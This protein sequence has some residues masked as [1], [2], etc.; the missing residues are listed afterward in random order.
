[1]TDISRVLVIGAG[2]MGS[3][4]GL[5]A[6][7]VGLE[8]RIKDVDHAS[9]VVAGD[10]TGLELVDDSFVPDLV[11]IATPPVHIPAE[12]SGAL[13]MFPQCTVIDIASIKSQVINEVETKDSDE[14]RFIATH[15]MA[16][17]ESAGA[18][19]ASFD[20]FKD[21]IWVMCPSS[22]TES[23]RAIA[24]ED[25]ISKLGAVP[26]TMTASEHDRTVAITSHAAQ[27]VSSVLAAQLLEISQTQVQVSGQGLRDMTRIAASNPHLWSEILLA[28]ASF[29]EPVLNKMAAELMNIASHLAGGDKESIEASLTAGNQGRALVPGKHGEQPTL[30]DTVAI[31]IEDTPGQ[32]AAIF[33]VAGAV[34]V[35][36]EDVRI[37]HALG[38]AV[39]VI[40][41]DVDPASAPK[42]RSALTSEGWTLRNSPLS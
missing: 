30:Y 2:L 6:R 9:S 32:L 26:V 10:I 34:Q 5:A 23:D 36:I 18:A 1:V 15:P 11:V 31:L 7:E 28:N 16:G 14:H 8:V 4:I 25:F 39:A 13:R 37:D 33:T 12:V 29:V 19:N 17:K 20:L 42:L 41:L 3:S 22:E 38:R 24:V 21:R 35:N 27:V 40:E